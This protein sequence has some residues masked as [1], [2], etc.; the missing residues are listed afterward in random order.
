MLNKVCGI[1]G[2]TKGNGWVVVISRQ[3]FESASKEDWEDVVNKAEDLAPI[4]ESQRSIWTTWRISV[5]KLTG[6]AYTILR[7]M[8]MLGHGGIGVAVVNGILK[9]A[10]A[11]ESGSVK[12]MFR[13]VIMKELMHGSSLVW[14]DEG[15]AG[16][17]SLY[18]L[19]R[20][21]RRFILNDMV[22]GSTMWTDVY[23]LALP[24]VYESVKTELEKEGNSFRALTDVFENN[25]RE[26][27]I[28]TLA[29]VHHYVLQAQG[30]EGCDVSR[31]E[32]IHWYSGRVMGFMGKLEEAA[33]VWEQ[34]LAIL[35]HQQGRNRRQ[36]SIEGLS[37]MPHHENRGKE[38]KSC[39]ATVHDS[40]DSGHKATG[41]RSRSAS[42][43]EGSVER[44]PAIHGHNKPHSDIAASLDNLG[45]VYERMGKLDKALERHEESLEMF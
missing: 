1:V 17:R 26:L 45:I 9:A 14:R 38:V 27:S 31:V 42:G 12:V 34:L 21:M 11:V 37:D 44:R 28:H 24:A 39:I 35:H 36:N 25:H 2:G 5:D 10:A 19:H 18:G 13:K 15:G 33:Q 30:S 23:S 41:Q 3:G 6:K 7:A 20:L 40:D 43:L 4:Q 22:R 32:S 29:L 8:A 16:G